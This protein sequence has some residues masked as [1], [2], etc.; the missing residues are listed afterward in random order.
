MLIGC[1]SNSGSSDGT[2]GSSNETGGQ[3]NGTGGATASGGAGGATTTDSGKKGCDMTAPAGDT[4]MVPDSTFAMG[5]NA[6][7]DMSC[8][9]DENPSHMVSISAFAIDKTEVTQAE[10]TSCV[11]AG[12]CTAPGCDWDCSQGTLPAGCVTWEDAKAYCA[13]VS[14]RLPTEAE[15]ELA[16]RGTDGRVYPWGNDAPTCD[17]E[18]LDGCGETAQAVGSHPTGASPFGALDMAGNVVEMVSD[19]YAADYYATSPAMNPPG[20]TSGAHF[21]GRGGG[22]KSEAVWQRTSARDTYDS[23]DSSASLGFRCAH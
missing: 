23:T 3:Q 11:Q 14:G 5:C 12:K 15:W 22:Y 1:G 17:L 8:K 21:V 13:F 19:Y 18:N 2:G 7:A 9:D 10:Y 4:V 20:P 16:A 6:A